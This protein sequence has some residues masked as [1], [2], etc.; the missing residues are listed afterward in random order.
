MC[1]TGSRERDPVAVDLERYRDVEWVSELPTIQRI[2]E[3]KGRDDAALTAPVLHAGAALAEIAVGRQWRRWVQ[4]TGAAA[5]GSAELERFGQ[6]AAEFEQ[7]P[8]I[9][10]AWSRTASSL[11]RGFADPARLQ[12]AVMDTQVDTL[13]RAYSQAAAD[14]PVIGWIVSFGALAVGVGQTIWAE[15]HG[16]KPGGMPLELDPAEDT[17]RGRELLD[18]A[19]TDDWTD[20]FSPHHD[21]GG[22]AWM[23]TERVEYGSGYKG[24]RIWWGG[25]DGRI[26]PLGQGLVPGGSVARLWQWRGKQ[27]S[28]GSTRLDNLFKALRLPIAAGKDFERNTVYGLEYFRPALQEV[29]QTLWARATARGPSLYLLDA[30]K[31]RER[32]AAYWQAVVTAIGQLVNNKEWGLAEIVKNV[33]WGSSGYSFPDWPSAMAPQPEIYDRIPAQYRDLLPIGWVST[34]ELE[35]LP[36][37]KTMEGRT[38]DWGHPGW[39]VTQ[40]GITAR[41]VDNLEAAQRRELGRVTVAYLTGSEPGLRPMM[42]LFDVRRRQLLE[43]PALR[44]VDFSRVPPGPWREEASARRR[45]LLAGAVALAEPAREPILTPR[46]PWG[47]G[48]LPTRGASRPAAFERPPARSGD[49]DP[50]GA[51]LA[52]ALGWLLL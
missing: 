41:Y 25:Q 11:V 52:A 14:A 29:S 16:A 7:L 24:G 26:V 21:A 15:N 6:F 1:P 27:A 9:A 37:G 38:I 22:G 19:G 42:E 39:W 30:A 12:D 47:V 4:R 33:A 8:A 13:T 44:L 28:T 23:Q 2:I 48:S 43:H 3:A 10:A 31:L 18:A 45:G 46:Q 40:R 50:A 5:A 49:R 32:W 51:L 35:V 17:A 20:L 36:G 34:G